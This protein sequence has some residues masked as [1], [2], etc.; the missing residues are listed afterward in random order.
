MMRSVLVLAALLLAACESTG[1]GSPAATGP[2]PYDGRWAGSVT[3]TGGA[4][5]PGRMSMTGTITGGVLDGQVA[6]DETY[7]FDAVI[8]PAGQMTDIEIDFPGGV[9]AN[10]AVAGEAIRGTW[11]ARTCSG[12]FEMARS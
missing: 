6:G 12:T 2:S 9:T 4:N 10:G 7:A 11:R 1:G 3:S 8:T 5:C